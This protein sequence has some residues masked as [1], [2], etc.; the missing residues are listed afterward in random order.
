MLAIFFLVVNSHLQYQ[1]WISRHNITGKGK[2]LTVI[3]VSFRWFC[4][5]GK[6]IGSDVAGFL[7]K[8]DAHFPLDYSNEN[9]VINMHEKAIE[10]FLIA[11][12]YYIIINST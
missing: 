12:T 7:F 4:G 10:R 6:L 3:F 11:I 8:R 5:V 9:I 1:L 2:L